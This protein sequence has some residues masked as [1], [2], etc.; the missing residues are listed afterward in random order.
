MY[1][2]RNPPAH[3]F[4]KEYLFTVYVLSTDLKTALEEWAEFRE[5]HFWHDELK[6]EICSSKY[7]FLCM[8][9]LVLDLSI[10]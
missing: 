6:M 8:E 10:A 2:H 5:D 7:T 9:K 1:L 4:F 3:P